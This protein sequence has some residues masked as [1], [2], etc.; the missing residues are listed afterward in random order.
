M[1]TMKGKLITLEPLNIAKHAEGYFLVSQ[2]ENIHKY[3]GNSIP[4]NTDEIITLLEKYEQYFINWM[5]I[6]NETNSVIGIIRLSK[7]QIEN[8]ISTAGESEIIASKYWR[9]GYMKETKKLFYQYVFN[10]LSIDTLY[11]DVWD[12]NIN[13]MK[14][15]E[16]SG[17]KLIETK[18]EFFTKT[19]TMSKKHIYLLSKNDYYLNN[20]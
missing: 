14:S 8:N 15:L 6:S 19:G 10:E 11:A 5:I 12:V 13:S 16:S 1:V 9:K 2:D 3:L 7:P 18:E 17:Y 4:N 20:K